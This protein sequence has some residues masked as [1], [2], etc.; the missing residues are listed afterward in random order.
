M[1]DV[2]GG[3]GHLDR[4]LLHSGVGRDRR[5]AVGR[6]ASVTVFRVQPRNRHRRRGVGSRS[7]HRPVRG[8]GQVSAGG[9]GAPRP[10]RPLFRQSERDQPELVPGQGARRGQPVRRAAGPHHYID[11][12]RQ[13]DGGPGPVRRVRPVRHA[14]R[15]QLW[16]DHVR[17]AGRPAQRGR[18][19]RVRG[20]RVGQRVRLHEGPA[21]GHCPVLP[22]RP[23][24]RRVLQ[25]LGRAESVMI[26]VRAC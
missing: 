24:R 1:A 16:A 9:R 2:Q 11:K 20:R 14:L 10:D 4:Y 6:R 26:A 3:R 21:I 17:A 7:G 18:L 25:Q 12:Q 8:H 13:G 22:D 23:R 5:R 15:G 19:A